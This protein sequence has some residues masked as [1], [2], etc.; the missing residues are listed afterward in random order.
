MGVEVVEQS[1][2][3]RREW[4]VKERVVLKKRNP[5]TLT[6]RTVHSVHG[7]KRIH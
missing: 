1:R 3:G 2:S 7:T 4:I 6:L 5:Y